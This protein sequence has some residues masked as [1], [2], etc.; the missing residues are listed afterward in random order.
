MGLAVGSK[1]LVVCSKPLAEL[2]CGLEDDPKAL[3]TEHSA[4]ETAAVEAQ[5]AFVV[6]VAIE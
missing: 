1:E 3:D 6:P 5:L 2:A 4:S